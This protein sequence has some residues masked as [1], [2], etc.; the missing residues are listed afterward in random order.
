VPPTLPTR[1]FQGT[2]VE[3]GVPR[4]GVPAAGTG[5]LDAWAGAVGPVVFTSH[6]SGG[7]AGTPPPA[8]SIRFLTW[9]LRVG[10]AALGALVKELQGSGDPFVLLLQEALRVGGGVPGEPPPRSATASRIADPL[11]PGR[12]RE[13][14]VAVAR[15]RGLAL[16]YAP[17]MRNGRRGDPPE[18]RGNA[19]LSSLPLSA[20]AALEL[21][22]ERQ[23]RVA[24]AA[25]VTSR[26]RGGEELPVHLLSVHLENRAPWRRFWRIPGAARAAQARALLAA[27]PAVDGTPVVL[28]GDLNSW[29]GQQREEAVR[30]LRRTFPHPA[31]IPDLPTHHWELGLDRQS[32]YLLFRLPPG[33]TGESSRMD[34]EGGS[35]HWP[36][37]GRIRTGTH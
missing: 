8:D 25:R 9:N 22:L 20:P 4:L 23:R 2:V 21:P 13:D 36:L 28:G 31:R 14:I 27:L 6:P 18:D 10:A 17:S 29:W 24:V 15:D 19:I 5:Q 26:G 33:W 12:E 7:A 34:D 16:L 30:V 3:P 32:D 37:E 1:D 35:D 11:P